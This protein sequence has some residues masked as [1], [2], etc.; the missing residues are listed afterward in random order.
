MDDLN[1]PYIERLL[2][3]NPLYA[4]ILNFRNTVLYGKEL[5]GEALLV[6]AVFS[7][8]SV[9]AGCYLFYRKQDNFILHI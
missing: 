1:K 6:A 7:L 5:D 9:V 8:F 3:L 4:L 2:K